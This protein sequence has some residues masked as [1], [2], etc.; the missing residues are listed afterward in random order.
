M[1]V[2]F[3]GLLLAAN[4]RLMYE[5][6]MVYYLRHFPPKNDNPIHERFKTTLSTTVQH[7]HATTKCILAG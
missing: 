4:D 1:V 3:V 6:L 2:M 7:Q 5:L